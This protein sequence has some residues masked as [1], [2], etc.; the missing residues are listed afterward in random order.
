MRGVN[1]QRPTMVGS[2]CSTASSSANA[3]AAGSSP[4]DL[5]RCT[6]ESL[7]TLWTVGGHRTFHHGLPRKR[8]LLCP[9]GNRHQP[10]LLLAYTWSWRDA[11]RESAQSP[12]FVTSVHRDALTQGRARHSHRR[13][14]GYDH[15][16]CHR[17][18]GAAPRRRR[19]LLQTQDLSRR[20]HSPGSFAA[21]SHTSGA[22]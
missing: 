5:L 16:T 4:A 12:S 18:R 8:S 3:K 6:R 22:S 13:E 20:G 11:D 10:A 2:R 14:N 1:G 17:P 19:V 21:P 15:F 7:T 9:E